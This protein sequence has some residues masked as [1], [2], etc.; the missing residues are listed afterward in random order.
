M[1]HNFVYFS[2]VFQFRPNLTILLCT[3]PLKSDGYNFQMTQDTPDPVMTR[4]N[5]GH[6]KKE[7]YIRV[8]SS[9]FDKYQLSFR[10]YLSVVSA[11]LTSFVLHAIHDASLC[12]WRI[13]I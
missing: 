10:I 12:T 3:V 1:I 8:R 6:F 5:H 9:N 13:F 4:I 11:V 7:T 2:P